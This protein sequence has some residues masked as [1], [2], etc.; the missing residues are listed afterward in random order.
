MFCFVFNFIYLSNLCI[1]CETQTHDPETQELHALLLT[2]PARCPTASVFW[3]WILLFSLSFISHPQVHQVY[4]IDIF[5]ISFLFLTSALNPLWYN[6]RHL[7]KITRLLKGPTN[8]PFL[9]YTLIYINSSHIIL[10]L[11]FL[12]NLITELDT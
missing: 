7:K 10:A 12:S 5:C 9:L 3:T 6:F 2:T 4:L 8:W 11:I 1:Q